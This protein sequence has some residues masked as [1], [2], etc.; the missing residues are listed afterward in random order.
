MSPS[1]VAVHSVRLQ[2]PG[3]S[4]PRNTPSPGPRLVSA[5]AGGGAVSPTPA[6]ATLP[7]SRSNSMQ[8]QL[9]TQLPSQL[10]SQLSM[11]RASSLTHAPRDNWF[12]AET[13]VELSPGSGTA[14]LA[15][16]W[17][18]RELYG[19]KHGTRALAAAQQQQQSIAQA[20]SHAAHARRQQEGGAEGGAAG[21]VNGK[22]ASGRRSGGSALAAYTPSAAEA[23]SASAASNAANASAAAGHA[24]GAAPYGGRAGRSLLPAPG[25]Q[26]A[27]AA[28]RVDSGNGRL[29]TVAPY[30]PQQHAAPPGALA[31]SPGH[32][33][34]VGVGVG[35]GVAQGSGLSR[36]AAPNGK[37]HPTKTY[38]TIMARAAV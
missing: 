8:R 27:V 12:Q 25:H 36:P 16:A 24:G 38:G 14:E 26:S 15:P 28:Q 3:F 20:A 23:T 37:F 7:S 21:G 11:Q 13:T 6:S 1:I 35:V 29:P 2:A 34:G 22:P 18:E 19:P 17:D 5:V 10:P 31:G 32:F 33:G 4:R 9:S 30:S